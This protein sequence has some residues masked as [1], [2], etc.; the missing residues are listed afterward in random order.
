MIIVWTKVRI[1]LKRYSP[2]TSNVAVMAADVS[3]SSPESSASTL[4][5]SLCLPLSP[6]LSV[7]LSLSLPCQSVTLSVSNG[8][9]H[10]KVL[11]SLPSSTL[12]LSQSLNI[13]GGREIKNDS[14]KK[15]ESNDTKYMGIVSSGQLWSTAEKRVFGPCFD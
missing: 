15:D 7:C 8:I 11:T 12:L 13:A 3:I 10:I 5:L 9:E 4:S 14:S 6:S 1:A 2:S